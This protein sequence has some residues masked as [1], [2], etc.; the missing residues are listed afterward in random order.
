MTP[1]AASA[2]GAAPGSQHGFSLVAVMAA[3]A[4]MTI[5]MGAAVPSWRYVMKNMREEELLFRGMQIA[6]AVERYQRKHG[7]APPNSIDDLVKG[8]FLRKAFTDPFAKDG[9]WRLLRPGEAGG[10]RFRARNRGKE[11]G[12]PGGEV[13][14]ER[15]S[16]VAGMGGFVGVASTHQDEAFRIFNG[17]TKYDEWFFVAGQPRILGKARTFGMGGQ[18]LPG[19]VPGM[20]RPGGRD[21][22][23]RPQTER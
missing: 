23:Q 22:K 2:R 7:G 11:R 6:D 3:I 9:K 8:K 18:G 5:M 16:A 1:P 17:Q 13:G 10:M 20:E 14:G 4:I 15:F 19:A 12:G 21:Q